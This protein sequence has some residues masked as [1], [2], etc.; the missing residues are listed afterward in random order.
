M[1]QRKAKIRNIRNSSCRFYESNNNLINVLKTESGLNEEAH[2]LT[3]TLLQYKDN[4][5]DA[6]KRIKYQLDK[7]LMEFKDIRSQ[8][9][10]EIVDFLEKES[11]PSVI[12]S[13]SK[14]K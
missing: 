6:T 3:V 5:Q 8:P 4:I 7:L 11:L 12:G 1:I 2:S 14:G 10:R 9:V 13:L